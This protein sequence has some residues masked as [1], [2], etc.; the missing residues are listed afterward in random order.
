MKEPATA[1][2]LPRQA[3]FVDLR[4]SA[5]PLAAWIARRL[6]DT[7]ITAPHVTLVWV[8]L[9]LGAAACYGL[10]GFGLALTG[11][12]LMQVKNILDAVDGSL[13]RLQARPSRIGRF[14]DSIGDAFIAAAIAAALGVAVARGRPLALAV[15]LA[16]A[17]LVFGLLQGS[18][19]NYYYV[20]YRVRQGGDTTSRVKEA[21]T[22]SDAMHYDGRP[23][24]LALLRVLIAAYN[25]IY[26]WQDL[27]VH[28]IDE[29][30]V[31]PLTSEGPGEEEDALRDDRRFLTAVSL[32]GPGVQILL[33][34]LLTVAGYWNLGAMLE[35]FLW[36][37]AAG[38]TS[39][40][41]A[42]ML[43]LRIRTKRAARLPAATV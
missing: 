30:A 9:G 14:L 21:L 24:A 20:C 11:A 38:G 28:R 35:L 5:R 2:K 32:L 7:R 25:W 43:L 8:V 36:I 26:G 17:A 15:S 22:E 33:L 40:A 27:V 31:R 39:Y 18:V 1:G 37:V 23:G 12:V 41:A 13:A 10:G 19:F 16:V 4:D 29:W 34:N 6:R 3:K 42:L